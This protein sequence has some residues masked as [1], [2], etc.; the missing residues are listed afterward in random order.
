M[1]MKLD[2][3]KDHSLFVNKN[4]LEDHLLFVNKTL[5]TAAEILGWSFRMDSINSDLNASAPDTYSREDREENLDI[6]E[7]I[8]KERRVRFEEYASI[9]SNLEIFILE[10]KYLEIDKKKLQLK[11]EETINGD[12]T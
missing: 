12:Q 5:Q 7:K 4:D 11:N 8:T 10:T 6:L 2:D 1:T 9:L 3:L